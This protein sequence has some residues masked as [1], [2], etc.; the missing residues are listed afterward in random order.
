MSN[1]TK[2]VYLHPEEYKIGWTHGLYD[3]RPDDGAFYGNSKE[4]IYAAGI[5]TNAEAVRLY[6]EGY[7]D[8]RATRLGC[9][10]IRSGKGLHQGIGRKV[11]AQGRPSSSAGPQKGLTNRHSKGRVPA[12]L[13]TASVPSNHAVPKPTYETPEHLAG[14]SHAGPSMPVLQSA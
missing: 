7:R 3:A 8:G 9:E 5:G 6:N 2:E 14:S 11:Q 1:R 13:K 10:L 4:M 12:S